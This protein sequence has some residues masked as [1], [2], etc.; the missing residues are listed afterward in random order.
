MA[1]QEGRDVGDGVRGLAEPVMVC[2]NKRRR[3]T[4]KQQV[5]ALRQFPVS[6]LERVFVEFTALF[7]E[8]VA[9][10]QRAREERRAFQRELREILIQ[11]AAAT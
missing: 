8:F 9:R 7:I 5:C 6:V 10:P 3:K 1:Q 4:E 2:V 11:Q